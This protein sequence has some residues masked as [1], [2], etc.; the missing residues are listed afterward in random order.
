[1]RLDANEIVPGLWQGSF[2]MPG[3]QVKDKGFTHLVLCAR[4]LQPPANLYPG[5]QVIH[6]PNDDSPIYGSLGEVELKTAVRAARRATE[7][8]KDGGRVL[9]TCA[10]GANR[11]GLVNGITLHLLYGWSGRKAIDQIRRKRK[12]QDGYPPLSNDEFVAAL[13]NLK[14]KAHLSTQ[15]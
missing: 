7:A 2:P 3:N 8:L 15:V 14:P 13:M 5:V 10:A 6:A 1:M 11:S 9:V 12:L 4:E